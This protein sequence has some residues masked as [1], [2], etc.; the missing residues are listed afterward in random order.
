V[1]NGVSDQTA[2]FL[3]LAAL[4]L[5]ADELGGALAIAHNGLGEL[6][7]HFQQCCLELPP[8]ALESAVICALPALWVAISTN[9]SLVEVSP[10]MVTRLKEPSA[11][12]L[13]RGCS[14]SGAI[15][16]SVARKPSMVAIL[17]RIMPAPLLMPVME[18]VLPPMPTLR[19][20]ALGKVSV[21]MMPSAA[22]A[23]LS[24]LAAAM[25]LGMPATMRS[26]G[27]S[28]MIT[29]VEKG[30]IWPA[31]RSS[32]GQRS[33]G[34]AGIGQTGGAGAGI[35][36][37]GVDDHGADAGAG[38]QMLAADLHGAAQKRFWVNTPATEAPSS[39]RN[40]VRSLRLACA[41]RLRSHQCERH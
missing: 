8:S 7:R 36:I 33:A 2:L 41:R 27:S 25:A 35:G 37:A 9:E 6:L 38:R 20:K 34:G 13:T 14:S 19:L 12:S 24:A 21:V 26:T 30:R 32:P 28:S 31:F 39:S 29:P 15:A 3:I 23:Q 4:D 10:S 5:D 18:T 11:S 16:A 40:T 22:V 17:G 1:G